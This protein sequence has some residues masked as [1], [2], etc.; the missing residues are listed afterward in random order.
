MT[1]ITATVD[2]VRTEAREFDLARA[3]IT[4][5]VFPIIAV[6][7]VIGK[8]WMLLGFTVGFV[9]AAGKVGFRAAKGQPTA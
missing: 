9:V 7:W 1:A 4:L 2:R 5:V 8:A 3:L 6:G